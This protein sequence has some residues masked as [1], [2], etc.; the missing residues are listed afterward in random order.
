MLKKLLKYDFKAILKYWWIAAISSIVLSFGGGWCITVFASEK[1][2]PTALYIVATLLII[3]V[4][5]GLL[6]FSILSVIFIFS[7]FY[8]NFFTDEGYL[9]FTLPVKRGQLL[10]SKLIS[11]TVTMILTYLV[12]IIDIV[13]MLVFALK[14]EIFSKVFWDNFRLIAQDMLDTLGIYF[15]AY[16]LEAVI[17]AVLLVVFSTLFLFC[18]ITIGSI[19]TKKAKVITSIGIYYAANSVFSFVVQMFWLFGIAG[20]EHW[21]LNMENEKLFGLLALIMLGS[22]L[23]ISIFCGLIYSIQYWMLDRKLNL[24]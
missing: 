17:L 16:T 4:V 24:S 23:F 8:K 7:R 14:D 19:I 22:I 15:Y 11:S 3:V 1:E 12:L 18:C 2:L 9:T 5:L 10:N 20:L 13:I 6:V 21:T